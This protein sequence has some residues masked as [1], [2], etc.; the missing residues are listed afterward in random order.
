MTSKKFSCAGLV[1]LAA[2]VLLAIVLSLPTFHGSYAQT[3]TTETPAAPAAAAPA[4]ST[5]AAC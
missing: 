3:S 4:A 1:A 2:A 5:A